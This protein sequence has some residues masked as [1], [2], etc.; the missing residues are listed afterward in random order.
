[1]QSSSHLKYVLSSWHNLLVFVF[2]HLASAGL[3]RGI[4]SEVT[5]C[6]LYLSK[7]SHF[8]SPWFLNGA[9]LHRLACLHQV[10]VILPYHPHVTSFLWWMKKQRLRGIGK[11]AQW[12]FTL[13][14]WTH[15][16]STTAFCRE[17]NVPLH[18]P[19]FALPGETTQGCLGGLG[20]LSNNS[21]SR[22]VQDIS[23]PFIP[24]ISIVCL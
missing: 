8:C 14:S 5:L 23:V 1:M 4:C 12:F 22:P 17:R 21:Y 11:P 20:L 10:F 13:N 18:R 19:S 24:Q 6:L 7:G 2:Y 3:V 16:F 9:L 15:C